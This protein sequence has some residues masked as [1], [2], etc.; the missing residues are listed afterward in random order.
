MNYGRLP[1]PGPKQNI[2]LFLT[3]HTLSLVP[4]ALVP[5]AAELRLLDLLAGKTVKRLYG[6]FG[7]VFCVVGHPKEQVGRACWLVGVAAS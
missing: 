5:C 3:S 7:D 1:N 2:Q 6:H 4:L